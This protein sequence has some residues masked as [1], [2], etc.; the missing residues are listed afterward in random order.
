MYR[1]AYNV[2]RLWKLRL[3]LFILFAISLLPILTTPN[4]LIV[5]NIHEKKQNSNNFLKNLKKIAILG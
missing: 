1:Q 2:N 3:C 4:T 5:Y